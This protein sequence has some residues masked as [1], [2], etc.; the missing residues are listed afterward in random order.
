MTSILSRIA[1]VALCLLAIALPAQAQDGSVTGVVRASVAGVGYSPAASPLATV[2]V[3]VLGAGDQVVASTLT[4]GEGTFRVDGVPAG[5]YTVVF[6][7]AGWEELRET[8]VQV[9]AGQATTLQVAMAE[10]VFNLNPI[11]V[12][13]S[14]SEEKVLEAPAAVQVVG[15]EDIAEQPAVTV[16]DHVEDLPAVDVLKA[17][18]QGAYVVVRGFNNIFSGATLTMTDNRIARV[19]SLR[20]NILYFNPTTNLDME[21]IEVV[22]GPGSAL[23]GP[24]ASSGVIHT[25]T[26]SPIDY[27]GGTLSFG[28]G[29]RSQGDVEG[30]D[31][32]LPAAAEG[33]ASSDEPVYM[34]EGRYAWRASETFG[35]KISG[36]YFTGLDYLYVDEEEVEPQAVAAACQAA[37]YDPTNPACAAF[38][39]DLDLT[40]AGDRALL[41]ERVDNVAGG[42]D[43]DLER[44]SVDLR[45]DWRPSE[46][47]SFILSGGRTQSVNSI[48]LT[49]LGAGQVKDW[50]Y[51]YG[52]LR[53]LY[54]SAFAQVFF[55]KSDNEDSYLLTSG[56]PIQ[57]NSSLLVAQLQN[58]TPLGERQRFIYGFDFLR[59]APASEGTINGQYEDEDEIN[60]YGGYI[61]SET[62]LGSQFDLTLAA[63]VDKSDALEDPVFSPRAALVYSPNDA[64]SIR[65]TFNRAFST[66]ST[67]NL[68]LDIS[69]RPAPLFGPFRY[70][71]RA[72]GVS[73]DGLQF[74]RRDGV[75][76]PDHYTPFGPAFGASPHQF[77]E[78]T[79]AQ[80]WN[81]ALAALALL[82]PDLASQLSMIPPPGVDDVDINLLS[83]NTGPGPQF[84]PT[85]GVEDGLEDLPPLKPTITNTFE[86][87]YKGL[88]A[89]RLLL[90]V[91]GYYSRIEDFISPLRVQSPN[92]FLD[93]ETLIAYLTPF[94]GPANAQ[95]VALGDGTLP[96]VATV[97]LGVIAVTESGGDRA[98]IALSYENLNDEVE[99]WGSELAATLLLTD[100]WELD[101]S[102]SLVSDNEFEDSQTGEV[103]LL[104]ASKAKG[105]AGV[106]YRNADI[107]FNGHFQSRFV[108]GYPFDSALYGGRVKGFA[109][110]DLNLGY[111]LPTAQGVWLTV[112]VQNIGDRGY[113]PTLG[114]PRLG[115]FA[116]L[117]LRWDF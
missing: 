50:A 78:T 36:Q 97:P 77:F 29:L 3:R 56:R 73:K 32:G 34:F 7:S 89:D 99:L 111:R 69:G 16:A 8:G 86:M 20:A 58:A 45:G 74:Q 12:T 47:L 92:V 46:D 79:P 48:D 61:Q 88:I 106:R 11:T 4:T 1:L 60:E 98:V 68:F 22:L 117:R 104:N 27:P 53:A 30:A 41:Q 91:N 57:D 105:A 64:H 38:D 14:R 44:W 24:N 43:F 85:L 42:R 52:Q 107:G 5:T 100:E 13:A 83:L 93:A 10:Q 108:D 63:R 102:V 33:F 87:G 90:S 109:V 116:M 51:N 55:N 59:T 81:E 28:V 39:G 114:A 72:Q 67:L 19:P 75:A 21:R 23:Y 94:I 115:R 65:A 112:D 6:T 25:I 40:M 71:I 80:L 26:K 84:V 70:D 66:P 2:Q 76:L 49:G 18:L 103:T 37:M 110:F 35:A 15:T 54:K 101:G 62:D 82:D 17:G 31:G 9:T 113:Q 96:G 95:A